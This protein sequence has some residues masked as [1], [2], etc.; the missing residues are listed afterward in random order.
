MK[1]LLISVTERQAIVLSE[2]SNELGISLSELIRRGLDIYIDILVK[3]DS[4]VRYT[5]VAG[6][7]SVDIECPKNKFKIFHDYLKANTDCISLKEKK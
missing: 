3:D 7:K 6:D 4:L 5:F 1:K 2:L